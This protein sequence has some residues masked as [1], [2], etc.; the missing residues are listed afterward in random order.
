MNHSP[1]PSLHQEILQFWTGAGARSGEG[2]DRVAEPR[3]AHGSG[4]EHGGPGLAGSVRKDSQRP[5]AVLWGPPP[6]L[7]RAL[8][9][10][11]R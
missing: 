6:D 1:T 4:E 2:A 3:W 8:K 11:M 5:E 9:L 10:W 7:G